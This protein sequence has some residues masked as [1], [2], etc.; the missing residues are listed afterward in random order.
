MIFKLEAPFVAFVDAIV[1]LPMFE[2]REGVNLESCLEVIDLKAV[3]ARI[4][5]SNAAAAVLKETVDLTCGSIGDFFSFVDIEEASMGR[6][7]ILIPLFCELQM[8][9]ARPLA[10]RRR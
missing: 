1:R 7:A 3:K 9:R 6:S 10:A 8:F 5:S 2:V 4:A